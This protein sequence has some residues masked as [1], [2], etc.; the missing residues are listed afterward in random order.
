[1][2][3]WPLL[4]PIL[5]LTVLAAS[6]YLAT[7]SDPPVVKGWPMTTD[8]NS[9]VV[10]VYSYLQAPLGVEEPD[11][12][13]RGFEFVD[14]LSQVART[15]PAPAN[16]ASGRIA[17]KA[18][19]KWYFGALQVDCV[20]SGFRITHLSAWRV[21]FWR[22]LARVTSYTWPANRAEWQQGDVENDTVLQFL[23]QRGRAAQ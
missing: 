21:R 6:W 4:L 9:P 14:A 2:Q 1:M 3:R 22:S 17:F 15:G 12:A 10:S 19:G 7:S 8:T 16:T 13:W 5:G 23:C 11:R 20:Q 18:G